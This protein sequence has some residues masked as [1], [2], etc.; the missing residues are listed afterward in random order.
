VKKT[1]FDIKD[2]F[3]SSFREGRHSVR[4]YLDGNRLRFTHYRFV[5][6]NFFRRYTKQAV[7]IGLCAVFL[8]GLGSGIPTA[9]AKYKIEKERLDREIP[10]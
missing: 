9:T 2:Y 7:V 3:A 6:F 8:Y 4:A 5:A 10:R 1:G